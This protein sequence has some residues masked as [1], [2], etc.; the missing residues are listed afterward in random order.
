MESHHMPSAV[1][2]WMLWAGLSAC[3]SPVGVARAQENLPEST[4]SLSD[5]QS[6]KPQQPATTGSPATEGGQEQEN[7]PAPTGSFA[8]APLPTSSP[9]PAPGLIPSFS[10]LS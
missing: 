10:F 9:P 7:P 3:I 2:R 5:S 1:F 4:G 8:F 6:N